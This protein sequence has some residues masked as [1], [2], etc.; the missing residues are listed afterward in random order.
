MDEFL[1]I[2]NNF[3]DNPVDPS[4]YGSSIKKMDSQ[5]IIAANEDKNVRIIKEIKFKMQ[6]GTI[7][8]SSTYRPLNCSNSVH[9]CQRQPWNAT[10]PFSTHHFQS[11]LSSSLSL[12]SSSS[13]QK[14]HARTAT[15]SL[16]VHHRFQFLAISTS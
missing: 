15:T 5:T 11:S 16:Q 14:H 9:N 7:V 4:P 8:L 2:K 3:S 12:S 1:P 6:C 13:D 10:H